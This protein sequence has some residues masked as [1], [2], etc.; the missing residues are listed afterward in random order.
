[1]CAQVDSLEHERAQLQGEL[2][3]LEADNKRHV[4]DIDFQD[5]EMS[6][7]KEAVASQVDELVRCA[8]CMLACMHPRRLPSQTSIQ[9]TMPGLLAAASLTARTA[10]TRYELLSSRHCVQVDL[11]EELSGKRAECTGLTRALEVK[12]I[13]LRDVQQKLSEGTAMLHQ[14]DIR[15]AQQTAE[16][17]ALQRELTKEQRDLADTQMHLASTQEQLDKAKHWNDIQVC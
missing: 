4:E 2:T 16:L 1:M 12:V 11:R 10:S 9:M 5:A 14:A 6:S 15:S 13:E 17:G 7:L 8:C 3:A